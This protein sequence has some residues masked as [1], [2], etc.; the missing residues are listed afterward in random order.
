MTNAAH[1]CTFHDRLFRL[2]NSDR[3][4]YFSPLDPISVFTLIRWC[5]ARDWFGDDLKVFGNYTERPTRQRPIAQK[6]TR[7][8]KPF[9]EIY[10][11][12]TTKNCNGDRLP[13]A[14]SFRVILRICKIS[15][16]KRRYRR[17]YDVRNFRR[18]RPIYCWHIA[19][20]AWLTNND[21]WIHLSKCTCFMIQCDVIADAPKNYKL[22]S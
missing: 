18:W 19:F 5:I 13:F 4:T 7:L 17:A 21:N 6:K 22:H 12:V 15:L 1:S 10:I 3:G 11:Q 9:T 20:I 14:S 16:V 2:Q 8:N